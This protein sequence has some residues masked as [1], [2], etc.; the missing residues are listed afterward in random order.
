M[1]MIE[2]INIEAILWYL[3]PR[4][5]SFR[6]KLPEFFGVR[7]RAW[8]SSTNANDGNWHRSV[9]VSAGSR[10]IPI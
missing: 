6:D 3:A 10:L 8:K 1:W 7:S 5:P 4:T 2:R 9:G